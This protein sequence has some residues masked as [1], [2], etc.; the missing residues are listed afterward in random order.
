MVSG[1]LTAIQD[2]V[3]DAISGAENEDLDTVRMGEFTVVLAYGPE[4]ILAGFVRGVVPRGLDRRFQDAL[5]TIHEEQA[6]TLASFAGDVSKFETSRP[7]L[8]GC[9]VGA[10]EVQPKSGRRW[11][12]AR[13]LLFGIP[14]LLIAALA[15][16]W[17]AAWQ[18][19]RNWRDLVQRIGSQPG[20]VVTG[21]GERGGQRYIEGLRDPMAGDLAPL[22]AAAGFTNRV[23]FRW[24]PY[25]SLQPRFAGERRYQ[26][27]KERLSDSEIRFAPGSAD[28]SADERATLERLGAEFGRLLEAA[29]SAGRDVKIEILGST[30]LTGDADL[31]VGLA[32]TRA[33]AVGSALESSGVPRDRLVARGLPPPCRVARAP[34][35]PACRNVVF[36]VLE[37]GRL[38]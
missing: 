18:T 24:E 6:A 9:L 29:T 25:H 20:I 16:W 5:D 28:V 12:A 30:D 27:A 8:E 14:L 35:D 4:M 23:S 19:E 2:F 15:W 13:L 38:P 34:H 10:G 36:R 22:V 37:A 1:M 31:N 3:R 32:Q 33:E 21:Y 7:V 17:L 11:S 26:S